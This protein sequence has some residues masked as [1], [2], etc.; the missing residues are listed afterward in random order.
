MKALQN[1]HERNKQPCLASTAKLTDRP[2]FLNIRGRWEPEMQT[3][4]TAKNSFSKTKAE[5]SESRLNYRLKAH[6][7][8]PF[9]FLHR[10][11][12]IGSTFYGRQ[13]HPAGVARGRHRHRLVMSQP[14]GGGGC[15]ASWCVCGRTSRASRHSCQ[16][17]MWG[18]CQAE[19]YRKYIYIYKKIK[20]DK[21]QKRK[22]DPQPFPPQINLNTNGKIT[23][24]VFFIEL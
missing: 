10:P 16:A 4:R 6:K 22:K 9:S 11:E 12:N 13:Q 5:G 7:T 21:S 1:I 3:H 2:L 24:A 14:D 8:A 19:A 23:S 17:V 15:G 20:K 18:I